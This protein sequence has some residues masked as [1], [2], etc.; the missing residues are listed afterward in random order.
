MEDLVKIAEQVLVSCLGVRRGEEVL[1]ITDDTR[2]EIGEAL[3]E[4]AGHLGCEGMLFVMRERDVS[5]QEPPRAIAE[6]M[7]AA[8]VVI[9][10]TA[11]SLTH[12]NARIQAAKAGTRVATMPGITREMFTKG[13]MTADYTAVE[14][15][16]AKITDML[17]KA[18]CARIEKSGKI[19]HIYLKGRKG[20]PSPGVYRENG[21]CGN[22]PS[23]EAYIAP[24]EDGADGEMLIDGSMVGIG[25]LESPLYMQIRGGKLCH[26][27][28]EKSENLDIL[29]K[30]QENATL[31]ELGIGTNE[32]AVLNGIILEDEKVYGTVHIAFGTNTSFGGVNKADCHM[33]GIILR[34]TL[35]LDD[36]LV[37]K[38][39]VFQV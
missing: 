13:A 11:K 4:A 25:K 14:K 1:V 31:C 35:Y 16:T 32:A 7:K 26:V 38:E 24:L 33:D 21:Q 9:A 8:D 17:S 18:D 3:Y 15:L 27:T 2:K 19:L 12:T 29:L 37:I 39:G 5:G 30:N 28:G 36:T 6:A 23:G 10:P 22:L 20:V 34:P